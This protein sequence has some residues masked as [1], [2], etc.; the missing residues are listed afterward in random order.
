MRI[1]LCDDHALFRDGLEL[2]LEQLGE[3]VEL[4]GVGDAE[5]ALAE[6]RAGE[7]DLDLVLLDLGLP[8]MDGFA[9]LERLRRDHPA[10]PVVML[11]ASE[12]A[13]DVKRALDAGAAGFIPKSTRGSV[14]LSAL[15]LV[16]SGGVYVP[17]LMLDAAEAAPAPDLTPRQVEVLRLMARGLTNKEI[18]GVLGIAAGTVKTHIVRIY[19][20][21]DVSNRTEAAM[22]MRELGLDEAG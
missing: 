22:R 21:L 16:L 17:P 10:V 9:A 5:A 12:R 18:S 6:V 15:R 2:V 8:G 1:L 3:P 7:D 14:L 20:V 13:R 19:E 11:S 4:T